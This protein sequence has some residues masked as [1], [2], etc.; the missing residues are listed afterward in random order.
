VIQLYSTAVDFDPATGRW[1]MWY[2]GHPTEVLLCTAFSRDGITWTK[3]SLGL[4]EWKGS[5]DNNPDKKD[6]L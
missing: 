5:R 1:Q 3:P 2:E 4:Q 6:K